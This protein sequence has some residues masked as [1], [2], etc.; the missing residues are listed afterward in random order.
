VA[1]VTIATERG[2]MPGHLAV[3]STPG[4]WPGVVVIHDVLGYTP[5]VKAHADWLA[6]EGF[7]ALAP[8]FMYWG[9]RVT[10]V[11]AIFRDLQNRRGRAF[12]EVESARQW[13][14]S[15]DDCTG[16]IGVIGFCM[17]GAFSLLLAP[18]HG[19]AASSVN[20]GTVP[21]DAE[22]V[23]NGACPI[24]GSFGGKDFTLRG[25][26]AKLESALTANGVVHDVVEYPDAS[27]SFMNDHKPGD[28]PRIVVVMGTLMGARYRE[29]PA[30][31]A[32]KRIST[33]FAEHLSVG[34]GNGS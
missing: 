17:G 32:R 25:A 34:A 33:F 30:N 15:R 10:C 2:N 29:K 11:R 7:L 18:G 6:G 4:P 22:S 28:G 31:D 24:V 3:P 19:F 5:D 13:L 9:G 20:Y 26:A 12:D 1:E 14:T 8:N 27:H 23:L 21:A 16:K